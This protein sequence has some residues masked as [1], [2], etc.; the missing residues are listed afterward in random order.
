MYNRAIDGMHQLLLGI[1][2][3]DGYWFVGEKRGTRLVKN[4]QHL[5]CF[6]PGML[7]LGAWHEK[8]EERK[9]RDLTTARALMYV[10]RIWIQES[11][12]QLNDGR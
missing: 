6:V 7:A 9:K 3:K 4:M 8:D 1:S 10:D 5:T 2:K 12:D 11:Y